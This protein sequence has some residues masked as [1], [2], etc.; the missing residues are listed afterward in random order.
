[1]FKPTIIAAAMTLCLAAG[2]ASAFAD[3]ASPS[4]NQTCPVDTDT[5]RDTGRPRT[6]G[7]GVRICGGQ[8]SG[9]V[10]V[11]TSGKEID[12]FLKY[13][14]GQ[15]DKSVAKQLGNVVHNFF[16]HL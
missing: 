1:M 13:P 7:T 16:S 11:G 4:S 14:I 10:E 12:H 3:Q 6:E 15:S 8:G 2:A 9:S 5:N